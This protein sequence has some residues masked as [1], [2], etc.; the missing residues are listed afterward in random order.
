MKFSG[1]NFFSK[2]T[3]KNIKLNLVRVIF[4]VLESKGL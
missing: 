1:V 4:H 3:P 2:K